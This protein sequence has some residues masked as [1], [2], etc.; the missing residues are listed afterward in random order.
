MPE[1]CPPPRLQHYYE[2]KTNLFQGKF[3]LIFTEEPHW[4]YEW[5]LCGQSARVGLVAKAIASS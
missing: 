5:H 3:N 4:P 2:Q 1:F